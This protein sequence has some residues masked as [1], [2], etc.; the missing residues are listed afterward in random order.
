M[1]PKTLNFINNLGMNFTTYPSFTKYTNTT[2]VKTNQ[3]YFDF[4]L[5]QFASIVPKEKKGK[6]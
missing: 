6:V 4:K 2:L 5:Y 1:C 3:T